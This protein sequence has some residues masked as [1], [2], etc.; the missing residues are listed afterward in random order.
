MTANTQA[1]S[2]RV[3]GYHEDMSLHDTLTLAGYTHRPRAR[4]SNGKREILDASGAVVLIASAG[5]T[6]AWLAGKKS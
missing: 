5:D 4:S 6:W 3:P 2:A 1:L